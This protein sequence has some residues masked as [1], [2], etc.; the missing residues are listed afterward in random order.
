MQVGKWGKKGEVMKKKKS[1][2]EGRFVFDHFYKFS[3]PNTTLKKN[4]PSTAT[5]FNAMSP[6]G[7]PWSTVT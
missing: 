6:Y 4:Q 3:P 5:T 2:S 7:S 1:E